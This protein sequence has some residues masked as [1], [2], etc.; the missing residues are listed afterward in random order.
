MELVYCR[1]WFCDVL[2]VRTTSKSGVFYDGSKVVVLAIMHYENVI[3]VIR[4]HK[5]NR[6]IPSPR[7]ERN[8]ASRC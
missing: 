3:T 4:K 5:K 8:I 2:F 1:I 6:N 7:G